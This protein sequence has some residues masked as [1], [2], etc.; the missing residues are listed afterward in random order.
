MWFTT[1][2]AITHSQVTQ[3]SFPI[4]EI[5]NFRTTPRYSVRCSCRFNVDNRR[6][7]FNVAIP[8]EENIHH[9]RRLVERSR[10]RRKRGATVGG[11]IGQSKADN[12]NE[13]S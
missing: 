8:V 5:S 9:R 2:A 1:T 7:S 13:K 12:E 11:K 4:T 6:S 3:A 10:T